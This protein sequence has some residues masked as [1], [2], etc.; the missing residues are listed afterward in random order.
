MDEA[1]AQ[2]SE[3]ELVMIFR[4][5]AS[6]LAGAVRGVL[7]PRADVREVLQESFLAAWSARSGLS[8]LRDPVAWVFVLTLNRARDHARRTSRRG[9]ELNLESAGIEEMNTQGMSARAGAGPALQLEHAEAHAA[10]R[11]AIVSLHES[12]KEVFLLRASGDR[13]FEGVA[14]ALD[15][16]VGTAKTRM[17]SALRK[18]RQSLAGHA[19]DGSQ[20]AEQQ[21]TST[22]PKTEDGR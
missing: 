1:S 11:E 10:A 9:R 7:G 16:P 6:G 18:L 8:E 17:R 21:D 4:T 20:Q 3:P 19:P 13:S 15:I 2:S 12:E 22:E 5:H 14:E